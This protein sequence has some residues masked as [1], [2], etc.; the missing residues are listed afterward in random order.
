MI[1]SKGLL[2]EFTKKIESGI[3]TSVVEKELLNITTSQMTAGIFKHW[4]FDNNLINSIENVDDIDNC[5]E[6]YLYK[7]QILDITKTVCNPCSYLSDDSIEK[8]LSKAKKYNMDL[9]LLIESIDTLKNRKW[10]L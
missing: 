9:G 10:C 8:A 7:T 1:I 2:D 4:E 6:E 3:D 5:D